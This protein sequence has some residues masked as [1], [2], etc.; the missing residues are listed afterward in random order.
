MGGVATNFF[1]AY[2]TGHLQNHAYS[3]IHIPTHTSTNEFILRWHVVDC[4]E[5]FK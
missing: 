2:T 5:N 1:C 4:L 3:Y